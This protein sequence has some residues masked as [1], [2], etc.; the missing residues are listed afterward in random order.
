MIQAI[1]GILTVFTVNLL[2]YWIKTQS[3]FSLISIVLLGLAIL[4]NLMATMMPTLLFELW[5][6]KARK[7]MAYAIG[8]WF[9]FAIGV[10]L[11]VSV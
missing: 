5:G 3:G 6:F 2:V 9:C 10:V 7:V 1:A 4:T 11:G 8:F